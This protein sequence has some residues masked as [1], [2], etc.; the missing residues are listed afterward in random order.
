VSKTRDDFLFATLDAISGPAGAALTGRQQA[1]NRVRT[2]GNNHSHNQG[3]SGKPIPRGDYWEKE[4]ETLPR[5]RLEKLQLKWLQDHLEF[6]YQ[7][8]PYYRRSFDESRVKP[9]DVKRLEDLRQFPFTDK[10]VERDRQLAVPDLGDMVAVP[11]EEIVY[12][13]ASSGSTGVATLSPFTQQDFDDFQNVESRL[14]WSMGMRPRDRYLHALNFTL[15]V[16]GPDVIGAQNLGALCIWA[17]TVASDRLLHIMQQFKPTITW[18]TP[19]YAWHLGETAL[20]QG[21]D[22]ARDLSIRKIIVAGEPGGSIPATRKAIEELWGADL[23][24]FYGLSDIFGACAGMCALKAGLHLAEDNILLEVLDPKTNEPVQDGEKGE[25]VL[26]TLRKAARPMIRFRT[27]DIITRLPSGC[28]CG[29]TSSRI[30]VQGRLDDMFIVS[31]VNVFPGDIEYVVRGMKELNGEYRVTVYTQDR[32]TRF[33]VEAESVGYVDGAGVRLGE[34]L[35]QQVKLRTGVRPSRVNI[36]ADGTLPRAT[37]KAK[38]L[39]VLGDAG[40][41]LKGTCT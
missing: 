25:M 37:H 15:F 5:R 13:S 40:E 26:T 14:Y 34:H 1:R 27:G 30:V 32:L 29:R 23:Y 11:E 33:D 36:L 2:K 20:K 18:T 19:S 31:G 21:I 35:G 3:L 10:A 17:G 9:G 24:D 6:A 38:R 7:R 22:P 12:V 8:S 4:L 28:P 39:V 41:G 16:G